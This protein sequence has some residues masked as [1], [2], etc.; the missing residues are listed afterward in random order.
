MNFSI[1]EIKHRINNSKLIK[2]FVVTILGSGA[3][4]IILVLATFICSNMLGKME[5]GELSFVRNT[6]NMI[7]CICAL[8]FSALCTKFTTEAKTSVASLHRLFLLFIFSLVVCFVIGLLLII[9]PEGKLL[10][11][12]STMTIVKFFKIIGVLLP[13]FMLQP[14]VEGVLRGLKKF[15]IIG[16]LQ[17][18]SS[19]F[20]LVVIFLGIKIDAV[21]YTHQTL[22][23]NS[24]V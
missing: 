5:F 12:L 10:E 8:N 18:L 16:I 17:T 19:F 14:L 7:L 2:G 9:T 23:T 15:D 11:L 13:L 22:P 20:Y 4:K 21:S 24:R 6:L 1:K 3:S